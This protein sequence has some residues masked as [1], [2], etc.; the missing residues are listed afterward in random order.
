MLIVQ[1]IVNYENK[2]PTKFHPGSN[3][4]SKTNLN[5]QLEILQ[6]I[7]IKRVPKKKRI[8]KYSENYRAQNMPQD[9]LGI[10]FPIKKC[11]SQNWGNSPKG[12]HGLFW[13]V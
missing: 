1:F 13:A 8:L 5:K 9:I 2:F 10:V 7:L 4:S 3:K 6:M 11:I 12:S